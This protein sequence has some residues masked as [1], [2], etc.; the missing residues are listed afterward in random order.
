MRVTLHPFEIRQVVLRTFEDFGARG[1]R[2]DLIE[3]VRLTAGECVARCYRAG[4]LMAMWLV[5]VGLLQFYDAAGNM[6]RTVNL[7]EEQE[8]HRMAA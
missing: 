4:G 6:L 8:T 1:G 7:F 2:T 5:D 3:T